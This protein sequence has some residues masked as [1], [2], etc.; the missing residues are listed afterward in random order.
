M[1]PEEYENDRDMYNYGGPGP[2][3]MRGRNGPRDDGMGPNYEGFEGSN[4]SEEVNKYFKLFVYLI[5]MG[6]A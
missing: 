5:K 6:S 2:G 4:M 1:R 3:P